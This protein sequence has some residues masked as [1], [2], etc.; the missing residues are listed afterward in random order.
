MF[1]DYIGRAVIRVPLFGQLTNGAFSAAIEAHD[2]VSDEKWSTSTYRSPSM[3]SG[4]VYY[5][6]LKEI[7]KA[8]RGEDYEPEKIRKAVPY[9]NAPIFGGL[10][11]AS[12]TE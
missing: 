11:K 7:A 4:H 10:L 2:L 12:Q 9:L 5:T 6:A 1:N 8:S 3:F